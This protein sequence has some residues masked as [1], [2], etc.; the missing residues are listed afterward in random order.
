M[1]LNQIISH[2]Q[3]GNFHLLMHTINTLP[4]LCYSIDLDTKLHIN[5]YREC[6]TF[7]EA[8][9]HF[10][11]DNIPCADMLSSLQHRHSVFWASFCEQQKK[12]KL[13]TNEP[14]NIHNLIDGNNRKND[15]LSKFR[16]LLRIAEVNTG[17]ATWRYFF[18]GHVF[19]V[20]RIRVG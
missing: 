5:V 18:P 4:E 19:R 17:N 8:D 2:D 11:L 7:M 1:C 6:I 15:L 14:R 16:K 10:K 20:V 3:E 13:I 9:E 12:I